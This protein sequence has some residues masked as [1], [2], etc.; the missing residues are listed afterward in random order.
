M[1]HSR[2]WD[3]SHLQ[4]TKLNGREASQ[5]STPPAHLPCYQ[6]KKIFPGNPLNRISFP[7]LWL[8][9]GHQTF[10]NCSLA[11]G[12]GVTM[13]VLRLVTNSSP[14]T[15]TIFFGLLPLVSERNLSYIIKE[16]HEQILLMKEAK[17]NNRENT[18]LHSIYPVF[19]SKIFGL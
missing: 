1:F 9:L 6:V 4:A 15:G 10:L 5:G 13:N 3:T 12:T 2:L 19:S 17:A 14:R 18:D 16:E 7:S 11:N 8:E